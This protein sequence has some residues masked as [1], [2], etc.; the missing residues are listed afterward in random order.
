MAKVYVAF[1]EYCE[2]TMDNVTEPYNSD[3]VIGVFDS[4]R[5]AVRR[6]RDLFMKDHE[7]VDEAYPND[8]CVTKN[9]PDAYEYLVNNTYRSCDRFSNSGTNMAIQYRYQSYD[10][11]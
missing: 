6:I 11:E 8:K 10:V 1:K 4:E 5:K 9:N 2:W 3:M 7:W